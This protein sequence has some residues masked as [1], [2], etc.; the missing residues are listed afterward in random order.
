MRSLLAFWMGGA[1]AAPVVADI[2][3]HAIFRGSA[4]SSADLLV[5]RPAGSSDLLRPAPA[6]PA[7]RLFS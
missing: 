3:V 1:A 7:S 2:P 6:S 5:V 4:S